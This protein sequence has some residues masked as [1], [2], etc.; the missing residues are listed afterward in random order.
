MSR[1]KDNR[2]SGEFPVATMA[3]Y[4]PDDQHASKVAVGIVTGAD[5]GPDPI[6]RWMAG[7]TDVRVDPKIQKE[8]VDF[9][10]SHGVTRVGCVDRIIGC[11]HEEGLDYPEGMA[12]CPMCT[13]WADKDRWSGEIED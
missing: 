5:S 1:H 8:I 6:R 3:Y 11:P 9:L 2:K 4:G 10:A 7:S 13:F 12:K